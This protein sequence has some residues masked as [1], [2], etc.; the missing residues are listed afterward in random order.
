MKETEY[1]FEH[2]GIKV[3]AKISILKDFAECTKFTKT[4]FSN[5][6]KILPN[7]FNYDDFE[8]IVIRCFLPENEE[9]KILQSSQRPQSFCVEIIEQF[10]E[11]NWKN[12]I[13]TIYKTLTCNPAESQFMYLIK[14]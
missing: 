1:E 11:E 2:L 13:I 9:L 5:S 10:V 12:N 4:P 3:T 14:K 8:Q 6:R 7:N